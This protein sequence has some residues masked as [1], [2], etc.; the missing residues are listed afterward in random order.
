MIRHI[1]GGLC[2]SEAQGMGWALERQWV[3]NP[4][5]FPPEQLS[6]LA[7]IAVD[8]SSHFPQLLGTAD[9]ALHGEFRDSLQ[10]YLRRSA[11]LIL[12]VLGV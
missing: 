8:L 6:L 9:A 12:A 2:L 7:A 4:S 10:I 3:I 5:G 1:R 11:S